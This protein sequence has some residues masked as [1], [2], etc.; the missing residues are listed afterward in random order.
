VVRAWVRWSVFSFGNKPAR[1]EFPQKDL[2]E[3]YERRAS[4]TGLWGLSDS[5]LSGFLATIGR[6]SVDV[7]PSESDM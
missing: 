7:R 1:V 2:G 5:P 4:Q 6:T 3:L